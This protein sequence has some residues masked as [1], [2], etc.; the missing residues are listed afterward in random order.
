[1]D[2]LT[3][4]TLGA[5]VGELVLGKKAGNKAIFWGAVAGTI[6]DLDVVFSPFLS[7]IEKLVYHR[8]FSHAL[9]FAFLLAPVLGYLTAKLHRNGEANWK[10]WTKLAFWCIL[11]HPLLDCFTTWGTQLFL[12]FSDYRVAFNSIFVIDPLYTLPF[13]AFAIAAMFFERKNRRRRILAG[14]GLGISSLYLLIAVGNKLYVNTVFESQLK[15]QG[16][17]YTGYITQPSPFNIILWNCTAEGDSGFWQGN[18]SLL[19]KNDQVRFRYIEKNHHLLE[20]LKNT[21]EIERFRWVT[22]GYFTVEKKAGLLQLNDLRFGQSDAGLF[23][24]GEYIFAYTVDY[25]E[26]SGDVQIV[27]AARRFYPMAELLPR[28]AGRIAGEKIAPVRSRSDSDLLKNYEKPA[29][30]AQ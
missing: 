29:N 15:A 26:K 22:G 1:M 21:W 7:D 5:A 20:P 25:D 2:S 14:L 13:L 24:D 11:T 6:P 19:D 8:G 18:Y 12:P 9:V 23:G 3:Q 4:I 10:E 17:E 16:I 27:R 28:F 30:S